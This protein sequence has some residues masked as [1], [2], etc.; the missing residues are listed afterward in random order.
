MEVTPALLGY[1]ALDTPLTFHL[2]CPDYRLGVNNSLLTVF[3]ACTLGTEEVIL[4]D[5]IK[6]LIILRV[7]SPSHICGHKA[8]GTGTWAGVHSTLYGLISKSCPLPVSSQPCPG[9]MLSWGTHLS[10]CNIPANSSTSRKPRYQLSLLNF[11][12]GIPV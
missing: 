1:A 11:I 9:G 10:S 5:P 12:V 6:L 8:L 2:Q 7:L 4:V 3:V